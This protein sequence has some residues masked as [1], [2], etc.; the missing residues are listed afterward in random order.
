[1]YSYK[2][3]QQGIRDKYDK[4]IIITTALLKQS[5]WGLNLEHENNNGSVP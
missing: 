1:M 2:N 5:I 4:K 3:A